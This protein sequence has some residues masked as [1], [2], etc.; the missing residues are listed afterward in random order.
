MN[1]HTY[2]RTYILYIII[3]NFEFERKLINTY[4]RIYVS[5]DLLNVCITMFVY[6]TGT[7]L[8]VSVIKL[9]FLVN[10]T[11]SAKI[12]SVHISI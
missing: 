11:D 10:A 6:S 8:Y 9:S 1:V 3:C 12:I 2:I 5:K 4:V 7:V